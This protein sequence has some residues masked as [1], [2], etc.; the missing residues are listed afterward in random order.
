MDEDWFDRCRRQPPPSP[1]HQIIK[2][3]IQTTDIRR[4]SSWRVLLSIA[5]TP[6]QCSTNRYENRLGWISA[7]YPS[8]SE[9]QVF[10]SVPGISFI[11]QNSKTWSI[12]HWQQENIGRTKSPISYLIKVK[13]T[14][15]SCV[16]SLLSLSLSPS[17]YLSLSI[18]LSLSPSLSLSLSQYL[19]LSLN[20]FIYLCISL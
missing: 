9:L 7:E 10:L 8:S 18:S 4:I 12:I 17:L 16:S 19:F 3:P 20:L 2:P 13:K 15:E 5:L 6:H 11:R 14:M 1:T